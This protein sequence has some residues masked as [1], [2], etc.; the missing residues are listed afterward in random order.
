MGE[1][2]GMHTHQLKMLIAAGL[3][4]ATM[5]FAQPPAVVINGRH[6]SAQ[7]RQLIARLE[8]AYQARVMPGRYWYDP[9]SGLWGYEGGPAAGAILPGLPL[10]GP[11]SARASNGNSGVFVNGRELHRLE[12]LSVSRCTSVQRGRYWMDAQG[13][14]GWEGQP[15]TFNLVALCRSTQQRSRLNG[16]PGNRG[17]YGHT[18]GDGTMV[19]SVFSDGTGVTC[20]PDGGCIFSSRN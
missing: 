17:W 10:G 9:L 12:V 7:E 5:G 14:G 18:S 8:Q 2:A 20:G 3:M 15:A 11:L 4:L 16:T 1:E 19:G 6:L 13:N